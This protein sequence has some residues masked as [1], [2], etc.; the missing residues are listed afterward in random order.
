MKSLSLVLAGL[1]FSMGAGWARADKSV[2]DILQKARVA[3]YAK[4]LTHGILHGDLVINASCRWDL[5]SL[6]MAVCDA[7]Y[8]FTKTNA[9]ANGF[10]I[11]VPDP[12]NGQPVVRFYGSDG[13]EYG[14]DHVEKK[15][16]RS[17]PLKTGRRHTSSAAAT[18]KAPASPRRPSQAPTA[19]LP[20]C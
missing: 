18:A 20:P 4:Y 17:D 13:R 1:V 19:R 10:R 8:L 16:A 11:E 15:I 14:F 9:F 7:A 6:K 3:Q 5:Q 2:S 12:V